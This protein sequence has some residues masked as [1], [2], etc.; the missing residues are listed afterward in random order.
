MAKKLSLADR[1]KAAQAKPAGPKLW[2]DKITDPNVR[3][4]LSEVKADFHAGEFA[5]KP[6]TLIHEF[7]VK[8]FGLSVGIQQFVRWLE[9]GPENGQA[10]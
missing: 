5:G 3:K 4:V 9:K 8:E 7:C 6:N 1:I 10:V 2:F